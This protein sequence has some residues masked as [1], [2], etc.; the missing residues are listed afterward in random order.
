MMTTRTRCNLLELEQ[1]DAGMDVP[2]LD[3]LAPELEVHLGDA[4]VLTRLPFLFFGRP[5]PGEPIIAS[6]VDTTRIWDTAFEENRKM[7]SLIFQKQ[8]RVGYVQPRGRGSLVVLSLLPTSDL[9]HSILDMLGVV[10]PVRIQMPQVKHALFRNPETGA[11][12]IILINTADEP[13]DTRVDLQPSIFNT[14][15]LHP[16]SLPRRAEISPDPGPGRFRAVLCSL[17]A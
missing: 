2:F 4:A 17:T 16:R 9:L 14:H 7:R 10:E 8:Y 15:P 3:H 1:P 13:V 12:Y 11:C 6:C 5:T